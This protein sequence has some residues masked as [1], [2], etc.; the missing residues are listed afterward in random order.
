M[1]SALAAFYAP[2]TTTTLPC[3]TT[4]R[5][6]HVPPT[7][8]TKP[9]LFFIHGFPSGAWDWRHQ[10]QHF[11][12]QGY[13]LIVPDL[14]GYGG[15][16][17]P[18]D[19]AAYLMKKMAAELV[20]LLDHL[21]VQTVIGIGHD[22]GC[23]ML[24]GLANH[25]RDRL[26]AM[27]FLDVGYTAPMPD[28]DLHEVCAQIESIIGYV[29]YGYWLFH[30]EDD[31][32]KVID[33]HAESYRSIVYC[34]DPDLWRTNL[35]PYGVLKEWTVNDRMCPMASW[36]EGEAKDVHAE[37]FSPANGGY[38]PPTNWY[39][40]I[41]RKLNNPD[42]AECAKTH[43]PIKQPVLLVTAAQDRICVAAI[44]EAI[45]KP[46]TEDL[47]IES[48]DTAHWVQLEKPDETNTVL[49]SFFEEVMAKSLA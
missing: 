4:Y 16:D 6:L 48:L 43:T 19:P 7:A 39:K 2:F 35:G 17:K 22:W 15:T 29:N 47:R 9:Y 20:E 42:E 40:V 36:F 1:A 46:H 32:G 11:L 34:A 23:N 24:S 12:A 31:A 33:E 18:S 13:G 37:L 3:G 30:N 26:Q 5:Y 49:E 41:T 25:H 27:A 38:G 8:P 45:T 28:F 21:S 44:Q 14:L 10:I